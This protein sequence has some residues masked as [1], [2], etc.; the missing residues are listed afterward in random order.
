MPEVTAS[1]ENA[2]E[3]V[4]QASAANGK[5]ASIFVQPKD[6]GHLQTYAIQFLDEAPKIAHL[7]LQ[8]E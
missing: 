1:A 5:R 4:L 8:V 3:T 7:S 2:D 6:G